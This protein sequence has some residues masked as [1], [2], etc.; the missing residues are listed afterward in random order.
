MRYQKVE[1]IMEELNR[2]G[3]YMGTSE[4]LETTIYK[5]LRKYGI[6]EQLD[7]NEYFELLKRLM[8][9]CAENDLKE[10]GFEYYEDNDW[11]HK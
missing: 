11:K 3:F 5:I 1:K 8:D 9:I 7:L 4:F 6:T 2:K 10:M